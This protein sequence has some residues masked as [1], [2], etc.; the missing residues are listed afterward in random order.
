MFNWLQKRI[1]GSHCLDLFAGTGA[2][3]FEAASRGAAYVQLVENNPAVARQLTDNIN[4]L[5]ADNI[6]LYQGDAFN[7]L[8]N[9]QQRFDLVFLDP[10]FKQDLLE[11]CCTMLAETSTV[12]QGGLLYIETAVDAE[13]P[14]RLEIIKQGKA[15]QVNYLLAELL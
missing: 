1:A 6:S 11:K 15:G 9:N 7:W 5:G 2:L 8:A 12:K 13:L 3:G 10:P 4:I 14:D